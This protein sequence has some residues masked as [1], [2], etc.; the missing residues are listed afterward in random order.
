MR[1]VLA[2]IIGVIIGLIGFAVLLL[3][4]YFISGMEVVTFVCHFMIVVIGFVLIC[5]AG[6]FVI[7]VYNERK[8]DGQRDNRHTPDRND[9]N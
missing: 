1:Y 3:G 8:K 6:L 9:N 5:L 4:I 7:C 2:V